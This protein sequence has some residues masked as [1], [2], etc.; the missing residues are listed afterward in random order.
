MAILQ[1]SAQ[2]D[3]AAKKF[4]TTPTKGGLGNGT[5]PS[6]GL[7]DELGASYGG[8]MVP[9]TE[10]FVPSNP[11]GGNHD[12]YA[13]AV[14]NSGLPPEIKEAMKKNP[15]PHADIP[16]NN[17]SEEAI[18]TFR[19]M[20]EEV[21]EE[22]IYNTYDEDDFDDMPVRLTGKPKRQ[23][24]EEHNIQ[25]NVSPELIKRLVNEEIKKVLP[26]VLPKVVEHYLQQ[27]LMKENL[28]I[29]RKIKTSN[30]R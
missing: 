16:T 10:E 13:E 12:G 23:I 14:D 28:D 6:R 5:R 24:N 19:G 7:Y 18:N 15:I 20:R 8:D 27:G 26:K 30:K 21:S 1:K 2:I 17:F 25:Q 11:I 22:P 3:K 9:M 29:L 4:D